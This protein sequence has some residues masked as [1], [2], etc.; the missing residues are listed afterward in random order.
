VCLRACLDRFGKS[1]PQR[2][3]I[4]G[5]PLYQ[6]SYPAHT[7]THTHIYTLVEGLPCLAEIDDSLISQ[8]VPVFLLLANAGRRNISGNTK[9]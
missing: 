3:S 2:D 7:N 6:L 1:R 8:S 9:K 5:R 4:P